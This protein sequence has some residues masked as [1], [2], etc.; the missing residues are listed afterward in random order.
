[1]T[2]QIR[3][4]LQASLGTGYTLDRELGGGGMS[5]VFVADEHRL[6]RKVVV[7]VLSP[8]LAQGISVERFEREIQTV[9]A[10]QHA[11]IVPVFTAGDTNGLPFYIMPFVEGESLRARL[12]RGPMPLAE[13][14]SVLRDVSRALAYAHRQGVVH[15]DIKP[16]NVLLS[17]GAAVVTDFGIAKAISASRTGVPGGTLTQIGTSIGTPAYMAP[18]QA[19]GDPNVDHRADLYAL[20]A[21]AYEMLSGQQVFADRTP[22]R[23]LAAHMSEAPQPITRLRADVPPVLAEL[24]MQCLEKDAANRPPSAG[25]ISRALE[26]TTSGSGMHAMPGILLGGPAMF[27]KALAM[28]GAAFVVVAILA[29]AAIA[30]IGLPGWVFPGALIVMA[31]G[32]P[33][34]LWTGYVQRVARRA[35]TATPTFTPGGSPGTAARGTIATMALQAAPRMTWRRTARGGMYAVGAFIA[36]IAAFMGMRA[37]GIGPFGSLSATGQ[38]NGRDQVI[39]TDFRTTNTD[40]SLGRVVSDAVRAGLQGTSAFDLVSPTAVV[41]A[42]R[43]MKLSPTVRLDSSIARQVAIREGIKAIVDGEI[44]GVSGGYIVALRLVRADSGLEMASFRETGDGPRGLIDAADKLARALRSKAGES[45]RR[46]NATPPLAQATT[47]SLDA[48]RMYSESQRANT[49]G[50]GTEAQETARE[51]VAIDSTFA[52]GWLNLAIQTSNWGGRQSTIDSAM[53]RAFRFKDRTAQHERDAITAHYYD[54]GPGRDRAKAVET[55]HRMLASGD[56]SSSTLIGLAEILRGQR[57]YAQAESLNLEAARRTPSSGTA[58]GNAIEMQVDQGRLDD[59]RETLKR[60]R[61]VA[62]QYGIARDVVIRYAAGDSAGVR[63]VFD[64]VRTANPSASLPGLE[65]NVE[66]GYLVMAGRLRDAGLER[67][68]A[69]GVG[70][71]T[72]PIVQQ[73][74]YARAGNLIK[75]TKA[76]GARLDSAV[77]LIPFGE[78]SQVDRPYLDAASALAEAGE[79]EKARA[80]LERYRTE[81]TDTSIVRADQPQMHNVLG[82][83]LVA[84]HKPKDAIAEFR[85]G[86]VGNDGAPANECAACLPLVLG[87]AFDAAAMPDSAIAMYEAYLATPFWRKDALP[88]NPVSV[89]LIHE[90]LGQLYEQV[91]QQARA[92]AHYLAFISLWK[93]ADPE[94][95]PRVQ[96]ARA[97]LARLSSMGPG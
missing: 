95:Q 72:A 42:L 59:A 29:K 43:R 92:A 79:P 27:R 22:Q 77:A 8:E 75:G 48:L 76:A 80:M 67:P 41:A 89:P 57:E 28:Y 78:M 38:L 84:E 88:L 9:A 82:D 70:D 40:S 45:L 10:L 7:K 13:V 1:M 83:I 74:D 66:R 87:H 58:L 21:M 14:I 86:D 61:A 32:L 12:G 49:L 93:N 2:Q 39:L 37:F 46:V 5:K 71:G 15:R 36:V 16:D 35:A 19:A 73:F 51:A 34:V 54:M 50:L 97:R 68:I 53:T 94:L 33:V 90:R 81:M 64:S 85:Q 91:G 20:G 55:Y 24:V 6:N 30:G 18:E 3:E 69:P 65:A 63:H 11:N 60:L 23:M 25:D 31:L 52:I 47:G 4:Q 96:D 56:S 26:T 62:P 17:E 44:T